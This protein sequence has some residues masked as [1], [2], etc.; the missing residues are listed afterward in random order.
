ML[1][2]TFRL[3]DKF[4]N[5]FLRLSIWLGEALVL[6]VYRLRLALISSLEALIFAVTQTAR[7]GQVIYETNEERRRAIMARRAAEAAMRPAIRE[8]PLKTQ[9]RALSMFTVVLMA[10][11]L[12]LVLWFTGSGQ[13]AGAPPRVPGGPLPL[14]SKA[15]PTAFPTIYPTAT[16]A[17][18][19]LRVGGSIVYSLHD[20]GHDNLWAFG[21]GQSAPIRL[22]NGPADDRDPVWSP[23]GTRIAFAS[24]REGNWELYVMDVATG[25]THRLTFDL[26]YEAAPTW[27]P[28]GKFIAYEG[29][30]DNN[31]D[32]YIIASDGSMNTPQRLTTNPAPDFSPAWSPAD[33]RRI[34]YVSLRDGK[35]EIYII[36]LDHPSEDQAVRFTANQDGDVDSPVWSPDS[37]LLA[38]HAQVDGYDLI[39]AKPVA[40]P[41]SD[42]L[43]IGK[44]RDPAW[45]PNGSSLIFAV[46][47]DAST[48]LVGGQVGNYGVSP[49]AMK[50]K[51]RASHPSWSSAPLPASL[52]QSGGLSASEV[53]P[54]YTEK[55]GSDRPNAPYNQIAKLNNV[56]APE[57]YL[58]DKVN[59]AF[60]ALRQAVSKQ[61]NVDFLG[62]IKDALWLLTRLPEPGQPRQDWHYAGRAVSL[63]KDLVLGNPPPIE[64]VREDIG[65]NTYWRLYIRVPDDL[66]GGQ[67]GEPLRRLPWDIASRSS[68]DPH[69]FEEGGQPKSAVPSGYYVD[70][71]R[72]AEDYGWIRVASERTW[73]SNYSSL[74]YWEYDKRDG[75]SWN[76]AMLQLYSQ[77]EINSFLSGPAQVPTPPPAPTDTPGPAKTAT[78]IPP[79]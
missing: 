73:R 65:V 20:H 76:D 45:S 11:L 42:P 43:V 31:L 70:F 50:V 35:P 3:T 5:A 72:I 17:A 15:P 4:S 9:N 38:Y 53:Q 30:E 51:G 2:R 24:H 40:Q 8:D 79:A 56:S 67:F 1:I 46:D 61:V 7:S 64:V 48:T 12:M 33:G 71:T 52:I 26:A 47:N 21:I 32:I 44:G 41:D 74:R 25:D 19:P 37:Q 59:D 28:D 6:Q 55:T 18:D 77:D 62:N 34:A 68:G 39:Y 22:T 16:T 66:Q 63:D 14:V 75:L 58:C 36:S 29:Y 13:T 10:S 78:P 57:P 60:D 49:L 54:L 23:D 27:S 69:A